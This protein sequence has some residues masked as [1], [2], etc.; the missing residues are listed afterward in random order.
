VHVN[1]S[2]KWLRQQGFIQTSKG[3]MVIPDWAGLAD[4]CAFRPLY[5]HPE[6]PR[7]LAA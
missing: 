1:R 3:R 4:F 5:L 2:L 7:T 6:G